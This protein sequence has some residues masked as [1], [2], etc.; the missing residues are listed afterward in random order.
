MANGMNARAFEE[1]VAR[2]DQAGYVAERAAEAVDGA[3][4]KVQ[5]YQELLAGAK[6]ALANA[7]REHKAAV[8]ERDSCASEVDDAQESNTFAYAEP[9]SA[10]GTTR[11]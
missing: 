2:R 3:T 10:S 4:R 11:E 5:K 7:K 9:A 1:L 8:N 6:D